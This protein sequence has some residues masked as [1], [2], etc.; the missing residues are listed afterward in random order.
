MPPRP[1]RKNPY[2]TPLNHAR[3]LEI[4]VMSHAD[5]PV[6][7]IGAGPVGLAAAAHLIRRGAKPIVFEAGPDVGHAVRQ[8]QHVRMFS[9]WRYNIDAAARTLLEQTGWRAPDLDHHPTG[10]EIVDDYLEP[11]A[12]VP[13]I[14]DALMLN[15]R[16]VAVGRRGFDK[17]RS[18]GRDDV[19]FIVTVAD[20]AGRQSTHE[21]RAV[22]DASGTFAAP[23]PAGS[24]GLPAIGEEEAK[25]RCFYGMPDVLGVERPRYAGRRVLVVGSGHSAM[26]VLL[27][28]AALRQQEP[29]TRIIWAMRRGDAA[30]V[31]GGGAADQLPERGQLGLR[32][33]AIV[34]SGQVEV[35][36]PFRA[37]RIEQS[38]AGLKIAGDTGCCIKEI[39]ADEIVVATGFRP[40]LSFLREVRLNLDPAL[41]CAAVLGPL[42]DPNVHSCGTVRPHGYVELKHPEKDFYI[43]GM[44][45][46]GRAPTFLLATGYEQVRSVAAALTGDVQAAARVELC[47]PETGVCSGPGIAGDAEAEAGCCGPSAKDEPAIAVP[48]PVRAK[49]G[50][51]CGPSQAK[52]RDTARAETA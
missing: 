36:A 37:L 22:L 29:A 33:R 38:P 10:A 51:C 17:V 27:D 35:A 15:A 9:P 8:W 41:E 14:R 23:N 49:A 43:V 52:P 30:S 2:R 46:Y 50:G 40:D 25:A 7:V 19:P 48:E 1:R 42:I 32:T 3:L 12:A 34:E 11:L 16:V 5:L 31:Y 26:N 44:K 21:V 6:A 45:S 4:S 39:K 47:L 20:A 28:L 24:G 18:A 13:A